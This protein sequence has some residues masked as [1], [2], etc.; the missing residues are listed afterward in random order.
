MPWCVQ[1]ISVPKTLA[2]IFPAGGRS[3]NRSGVGSSAVFH[4]MEAFF[5]LW[6]SSSGPNSKKI[7]PFGSVTAEEFETCPPCITSGSQE[8]GISGTIIHIRVL[9]P[10]RYLTVGVW[11]ELN[12][13]TLYQVEQNTWYWVWVPCKSGDSGTPLLNKRDDRVPPGIWWE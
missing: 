9:Q 3:L 5:A 11:H 10:C 12:N 13:N 4:I 7:F 2:M 1:T 8:W 6:E